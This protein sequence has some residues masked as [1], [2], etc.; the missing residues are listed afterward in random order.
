[1]IPSG[2]TGRARS[3]AELLDVEASHSEND[4]RV[5]GFIAV[6]P[7]DPDRSLG[8]AVH[9]AYRGDG[10][11]VCRLVCVNR[12]VNH[13][14]LAPPS[15]APSLAVC[16]VTSLALA[17]C[18]NEEPSPPDAAIAEDASEPR[19]DAE[20]PEPD[21]ATAACEVM[22]EPEPPLPEPARHTPR[23]AFSPW[24]S[25][26]ISDRADS[27]AF[28]AGFRERDI[29]VGVL[30]LDSPWDSHY[31]DFTPS[32]SRYPDFTDLVETLHDDDVRVVL[33]VTQTTNY[34]S[35]DAEEGG[36][37]YR[38]SARTWREGRACGFFVDDGELV[39]WWKGRGSAVDFFHPR[40]RAWWH[41]QQRYLLEEARIDGWK[42]DFA[43]SY[44]AEEHDDGLVRTAAGE[45]S[46]QTYSEAYY[47]DY[48]AWGVQQRGR[49][50]LTMVRPWDVSYDRRGRFHARPEH[51]PVAW[52]GDNRRDWVGLSDALDHILVSA[53][54][55]YVVLGADLGGYLDR[56]DLALTTLIPFDLEVF[57]RWTALAAMTPFMQLHSRGNLAPWTVPGTAEEQAETTAI[58]RYWAWLHE[59]LVPFWYSLTEEAYAR[60]A[61]GALQPILHPARE[62]EAWPGDYAFSIGEALF[63]APIVEAGGVR[64][65][66]LPEG[67]AYYDFASLGGAPIPGGT[68][69]A[70]YDASDRARLPVFVREGAIIPMA[71][72][73]DVTRLGTAASADH[74]SVLVFP[75]LTP[76]SFVLHEEDDTTTTITASRSA[77][78][79]DEAR[80]SFDPPRASLVLRVRTE[81][82]PSAV[83]RD[84]AALPAATSREALDAMDEGYFFDADARAT[85]IRTAD[86]SSEIVIAR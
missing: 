75:S 41:E 47:R 71:I 72:T 44:L 56:D 27:L 32:P 77:A 29:P 38:G 34:R 15:L 50:F 17:G 16:L 3:D 42:L 26:D 5:Q 33:W 60:S 8:G 76:T 82:T 36:D 62:P 58:Y 78:P 28:V 67:A 6:A 64:D 70:A 1:M 2:A 18:P 81:A 54:A 25:K 79:A 7:R 22:V 84:G 37:V 49:D 46:F 86:A 85:W 43:E 19:L 21:A 68:T 48:L 80:I 20:V 55:G 23:W 53:S 61:G 69:L 39:N 24:I 45:V 30:V 83:E 4:S 74:L 11:G 59:Q 13:S 35:F 52:V 65:V 40:A 66:T 10:Q 63:V 12:L 9:G 57:Q 51:A 73:N 14:T 31:T